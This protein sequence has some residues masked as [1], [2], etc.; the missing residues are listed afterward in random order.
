MRMLFFG[1]TKAVGARNGNEILK[2]SLL[3][4]SDWY[5]LLLNFFI[6][7]SIIKTELICH[8]ASILHNFGLFIAKS[9]LFFSSIQFPPF[10]MGTNVRA[11]ILVCF[12]CVEGIMLRYNN[13]DKTAERM[14]NVGNNVEP[15]INLMSRRHFCNKCLDR[16]NVL[17][18][19]F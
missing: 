19:P 16:E 7:Y 15:S 14:E 17:N 3:K 10:H 6:W 18:R 13:F 11:D 12:I 8:S 1:Q 9:D 5:F 4:K 2:I